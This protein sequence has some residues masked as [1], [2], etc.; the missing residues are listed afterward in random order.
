M[1]HLL[2][3]ILVCSFGCSAA[4][5]KSKDQPK[6]ST[7]LKLIVMHFH[8]HMR[9]GLWEKAS[10]YMD[11]SVRY[12]FLGRF[13]ELGEDYKITDLEIKQVLR[14][15]EESTVEVEQQWYHEPNMTVQ[16]ERLM[17]VWKLGSDGWRLSERTPKKEYRR[18][19]KEEADKAKKLAEEKAALL[20]TGE[21]PS[22]QPETAAPQ[23]E[24]AAP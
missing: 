21:E 18:K 19:K 7:D 6:E 9:W 10:M 2:L 1:K 11:E 24:S 20:K 22:I 13:E 15:P 5:K 12:K 23:P 8:Q 16:K 14:T 17:E 3:I 4:M